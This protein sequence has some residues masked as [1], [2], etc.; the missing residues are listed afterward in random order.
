MN[1][2]CSGIEKNRILEPE[3]PFCSSCSDVMPNIS[4][5]TFFSEGTSNNCKIRNMREPVSINTVTTNDFKTKLHLILFKSHRY[6]P[7]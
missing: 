7:H 4:A 2:G 1:E 6:I 5:H 3:H